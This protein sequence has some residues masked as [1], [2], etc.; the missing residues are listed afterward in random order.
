MFR[1]KLQQHKKNIAI[2]ALRGT[3]LLGALAIFISPSPLNLAPKA[4]A[5]QIAL[6]AT[7]FT[8]ISISHSQ[9][10]PTVA[11]TKT[12]PLAPPIQKPTN[13]TEGNKAPTTPPSPR[14][15]KVKEVA[16]NRVDT[17][18]NS[19]PKPSDKP[20]QEIS[21][22]TEKPKV[23]AASAQQVLAAAN[24][25]SLSNNDVASDVAVVTQPLFRESPTPPHYPSSARRRGLEGTVILEVS[26]D[27][28]GRQT[29]LRIHHSSG[30]S[31]LDNSALKAVEL[32]KFQAHSVNGLSV[33]S[34][35]HVPVSFA[36][37]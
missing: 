13:K 25:S 29:D 19:T 2:C 14:S 24:T 16:L 6:N 10:R 8:S 23:D 9:P 28:L 18:S 26:L 3:F 30:Q 27:S 4:Y 34:R 33:A 20:T 36:L 7:Q 37:N 31:A 21:K 12:P 1:L 17:T 32:W 5:T 11:D 22:G 15:T 35:V